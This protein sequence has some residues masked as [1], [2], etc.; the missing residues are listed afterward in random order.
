MIDGR[1]KGGR[2]MLALCRVLSSWLCPQQVTAKTP[3]YAL[4]VRVRPTIQSPPDG[5]R[6]A[7]DLIVSPSAQPFR[8]NI[9]A[10]NQ[11]GWSMDGMFDASSWPP[12]MWWEQCCAQA[13]KAKEKP[14]LIFTRNRRPS[15]VMLHL[16]DA[17]A[18]DIKPL[19]GQLAAVE[20]SGLHP[21]EMVVVCL[22]ADLV[23]VPRPNARKNRR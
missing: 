10:K 18:L 22:L 12:W 11:E 3:A 7:G 1:N 15:Y 21:K 16:A 20:R 19:A 14:L 6:Y 2:Y 17:D 23:R 5:W 8:S 9:E 13:A 4:P